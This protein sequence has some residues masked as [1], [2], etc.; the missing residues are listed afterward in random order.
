MLILLKLFVDK[1]HNYEFFKKSTLCIF[2]V[3]QSFWY[4][5]LIIL[6]L[7]S[8]IQL[9]N[10]RS[11]FRMKKNISILFNHNPIIYL[12]ILRSIRNRFLFC[13]FSPKAYHVVC[14]FQAPTNR[15]INRRDVVRRAEPGERANNL[16]TD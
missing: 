3:A 6:F 2:Q 1:Y 14:G 15:A 11:L 8:L 5:W 13:I 9:K 16:T 12:S 10:Q 7:L 4:I